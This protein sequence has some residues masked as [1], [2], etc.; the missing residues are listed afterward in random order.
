MTRQRVM[1]KS[2]RRIDYDGKTKN[3]NDNDSKI[4][5]R[6][7][8]MVKMKKKNKNKMTSKQHN[9]GLLIIGLVSDDCLSLSQ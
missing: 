3:S 4:Q 7:R 1:Q 2:Q 6:I 5:T 9:C 8:R